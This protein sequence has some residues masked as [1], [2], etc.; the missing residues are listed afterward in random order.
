MIMDHHALPK[1][2]SIGRLYVVGHQHPLSK[3]RRL[4]MYHGLATFYVKEEH[5][6]V[7]GHNF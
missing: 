6:E 5:S 2:L 1:Q 3:R 4:S 7:V